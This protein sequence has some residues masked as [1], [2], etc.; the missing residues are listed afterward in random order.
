MG[1]NFR[2]MEIVNDTKAIIDD[3]Y[4]ARI[5][6]VLDIEKNSKNIYDLIQNGFALGYAQGMK[7]ARAEMRKA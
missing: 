5:Q 4:A 1:V 7:A 3:R 6:N 2:T